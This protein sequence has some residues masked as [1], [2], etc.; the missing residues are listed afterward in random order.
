MSKRIDRRTRKLT[1]P[2][3]FK[4]LKDNSVFKGKFENDEILNLIKQN[5]YRY[6][7]IKN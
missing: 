1:Y 2:E 3:M 4:N 5:R 6:P 7:S